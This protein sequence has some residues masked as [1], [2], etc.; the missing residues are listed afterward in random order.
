MNRTRFVILAAM[1]IAAAL[2]LAGCKDNDRIKISSI[3]ERPDKYMDRN[4]TVAGEVTRT[5]ALN[6]FIA[7]AGAY[8][9]DDGTGKIWVITRTGVPR[10][11]AQV[12]LKGHVGSGVRIGSEMFGAVIR[13]DER[14]IRY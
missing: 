4:V 12:G 14:R 5:Y 9:I 10:E 6:L 7:E 8:Q 13:E 2:V 3:L 11:G 1:L